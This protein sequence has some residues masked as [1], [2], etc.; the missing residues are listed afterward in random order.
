MSS[1]KCVAIIVLAI[2]SASCTNLRDKSHPL[3]TFKV[4]DGLYEERYIVD[5]GNATTT[6]IETSY[7]TDSVHFRKF[8]TTYDPYYGPNYVVKGDV[9]FVT[10][11]TDGYPLKDSIVTKRFTLSIRDLQAEGA[12]D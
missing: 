9:V 11:Y 7:L 3:P 5:P 8:I 1:K 10:F 2:L 12:W 4:G 6:G